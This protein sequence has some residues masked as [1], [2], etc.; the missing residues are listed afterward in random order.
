MSDEKE[1]LL[2]KALL[3]KSR[4]SSVKESYSKW[5]EQDKTLGLLLKKLLL[6]DKFQLTESEIEAILK[7]I[8]EQHE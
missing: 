5:K 8:G 7:L 6:K 1:S 2:W 3:T 4:Q